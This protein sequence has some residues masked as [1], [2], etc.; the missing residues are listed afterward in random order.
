MSV[1]SGGARKHHGQ[2]THAEVENADFRRRL[3]PSILAQIG[4]I[5]GQ[6]RWQLVDTRQ[7]R[8]RPTLV[9]ILGYANLDGD[10]ARPQ[11]ND[12]DDSSRVGDEVLPR[13]D[14][15]VI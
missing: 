12:L 3:R 5:H 14:A 11:V 15:I 1:T 10:W 2:A 13:S 6:L 8:H 7:C 9:A 4:Q